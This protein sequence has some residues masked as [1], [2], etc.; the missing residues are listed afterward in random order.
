MLFMLAIGVAMIRRQ[1]LNCSCFGLLY[2]ERVGW[3]TQIRDG[4]LVILAAFL[5]VTDDA[6]LALHSLS[7]DHSL[8]L[9]VA[10]LLLTATVVL[11]SVAGGIVSSRHST[12]VDRT[13]IQP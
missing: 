13:Q 7:Q 8:P 6:T 11:A 9:T 3:G 10:T 4:I 12:P 2:R 1:N 5:A